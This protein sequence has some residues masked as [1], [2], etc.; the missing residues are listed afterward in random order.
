VGKATEANNS[1]TNF[2]EVKNVEFN[3]DDL[4]NLQNQIIRAVTTALNLP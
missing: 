4:A 3:R 2:Q 1:P